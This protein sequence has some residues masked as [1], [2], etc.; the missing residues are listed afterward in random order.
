MSNFSY[1]DSDHHRNVRDLHNSHADSV[2]ISISTLRPNE[3]RECDLFRTSRYV[4]KTI[5]F[6]RGKSFL[7]FG[8]GNGALSKYFLEETSNFVGIDYSE[9]ALQV[10]KRDL[11]NDRF[12]HATLLSDLNEID[13]E[14][15]FDFV[16]AWASFH[17]V[18]NVDEAIEIL[19]GLIS[20][21][22]HKGRLIIGNL[23]L[24]DTDIGISLQISVGDSKLIKIRKFLRFVFN[25]EGNGI[26]T[27]NWRLKAL[28]FAAISKLRKVE[29]PLENTGSVS[30]CLDFNLSMLH[31][32]LSRYEDSITYRIIPTFN[33]APLNFGRCDVVI[34]KIGQSF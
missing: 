10:F 9:L 15:E 27:L 2:H 30:G 11:C 19:S 33:F 7:D 21:L 22:K 31:R 14:I 18:S 1:M 25:F 4:K 28:L 23:P 20:S 12:E 17:Y 32:L 24:T 29:D 6:T 13:S 16:L 26:S 34:T 3:T 5:Q 8:C